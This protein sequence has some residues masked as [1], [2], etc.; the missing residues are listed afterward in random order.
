MLSTSAPE[1]VG[2]SMWSEVSSKWTEIRVMSLG[3]TSSKACKG[4]QR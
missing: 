2:A 3:S 1:S 4:A